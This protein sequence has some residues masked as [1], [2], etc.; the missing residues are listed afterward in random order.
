METTPIETDLEAAEFLKVARENIL[1]ELKKRIIGQ[2]DVIDQLLI[3]LFSQGHCLLVGVPGLAKTLLISTFAK[4]LK[5]PFNRIQFT[6]DLMPSDIIGTDIIEEEINT[7]KRAFRFIKGPVFANVVLADEINRTPPKTQA[8]LLQAMQEYK[9]TAGGNTYDLELP[10]FVL[11]T[12][13]PIE[14]EGT[15]PL[16]EA[17]LDRFMFNIYID[18]PEKSEEKEIVLTTTSAYEPEIGA[19]ISGEEVLR[20]QQ[21]VRKVP[22][23]EAMVDYAVELSLN[24]RPS[25]PDAPDFIKDWVN[26]GAGPRASQYLVL[27]AKA[28]AIMH[29][30]YHVSYEDIKAV[31]KPVLRHRILTNFNAEADGI[32]SLDIISQLLEKVEPSEVD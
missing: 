21:I 11:A 15:Y 2:S 23:A 19:I 24:T 13:N 31:A 14:Q 32:T 1:T 9:V 6:P 25:H 26:W 7:G 27:G 5:L 18:Y 3:A 10:F 8:A 28:R 4:I 30:R 22:I 12:Q 20:L 17:Q 16:P 29:G